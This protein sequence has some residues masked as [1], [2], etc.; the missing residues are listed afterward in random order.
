MPHDD[1]ERTW[2]VQIEPNGASGY[3][4]DSGQNGSA[5]ASGTQSY[6]TER[7]GEKGHKASSPSTQHKFLMHQLSEHEHRLIEE[8]RSAVGD[9]STSSRKPTASGFTR[10]ATAGQFSCF[11]AVLI[12]GLP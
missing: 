5:T 4:A 8:L 1:A 9:T 7:W 6:Y 2:R 12:L 11:I 3:E 10:S